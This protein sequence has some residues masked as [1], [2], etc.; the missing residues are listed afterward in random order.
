VLPRGDDER[1]DSAD[2][3]RLLTLTD[4]VF[5]IA[6]TLLV[7][8]LDVPDGLTSNGDVWKAVTDQAANFLALGIS[9]VVIAAFWSGHRYKFRGVERFNG[10]IMW[11]NFGFLASITLMP[12]TTKLI[13]DYGD[14][15]S[16]VM[17]YAA[18]VAIAATVMTLMYILVARLQQRPLSL[19]TVID[20]G[21][22]DT[23][24]VFAVSIPVAFWVSTTAAKWMWV[25]LAFSGHL[26][27]R[28]PGV[29]EQSQE[30]ADR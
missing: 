20:S 29:K 9:F 13:A 5:A 4:G 21:T 30:T 6:L 17:I 12:F 28:V 10:P 11:M 19:A 15:K 24:V 26:L 14:Y 3:G 23:A 2:V 18:N 22:F 8:D 25:I 7:L 1:Q 27:A 16:P